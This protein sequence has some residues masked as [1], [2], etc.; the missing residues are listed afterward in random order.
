MFSLR[1]K[2]GVQRNSVVKKWLLISLVVLAAGVAI[3]SVICIGWLYMR[4]VQG[5]S[6]A[7][8]CVWP[9]TAIAWVDVNADGIRDVGEP[10]LPGVKFYIDDV[11]NDLEKVGEGVSDWYGE[12]SFSVWLPG[13]PRVEFEVYPEVP[14]GYRLTTLSRL[15][16]SQTPEFGF[17]YL[18]GVP[19]VTPRPPSLMLTCT[20]Y[21]LYPHVDAY[22][23]GMVV[24]SDGTVWIATAGAGVALFDPGS[25]SWTV[26]TTEDGLASNTV[27]GIALASDGVLW[28]GTDGGVSRFDGFT[29]ITYTNQ[30]GL[31]YNG[32]MDVAVALDGAIWFA[33]GQGISRFDPNT[34]T[35]T[36]D[37]AGQIFNEIAV[38][39]DGTVWTAV[40]TKEVA[41]NSPPQ[42]PGGSREWSTYKHHSSLRY[43][44]EITVAPDDTIWFA[45]Y[46]GVSHYTPAT[47]SWVHYTA[48]DVDAGLPEDHTTAITIGP[49]ASVWIGTDSRGVVRFIPA[50]KKSGTDVWIIYDIRSGL[51]A[52]HI[53]HIVFA[54]DGAVWFGTGDFLNRCVFEG[55]E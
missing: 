46:N 7:G 47:D 1:S 53:T 15:S 30:D 35:W 13:C 42:E 29:W 21:P 51:A 33:T 27:R 41:R 24:A 3:C 16:A 55:E 2:I 43:I 6:A 34:N 26:Y 19:T 54:P 22:L 25:E 23:E 40:P 44:E 52:N 45:A 10:P 14:A 5:L 31:V 9:G 48:D 12:A 38:T 4:S 32:V 8:D 50:S 18:P 39:P 28:F 36:M 17:G 20:E 49:D 11:R 37:A